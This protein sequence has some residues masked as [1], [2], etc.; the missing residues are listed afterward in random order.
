MQRR[1]GFTL[2]E[3]L[4]VIAIIAILAAILFPVFTNAKKAGQKASCA[5]GIKQLSGAFQIYADDNGNTVPPNYTTCNRPYPNG[6][7]NHQNAWLWMHYLYPYV[8]NVKVYNCPA[9]RGIFKG[10]YFWEDPKSGLYMGASYAYNRWLGRY[11]PPFDSERVSFGQISRTTV[12]PL[13][14]DCFYYLMGPKSVD[15]LGNDYPPTARHNEMAVM[16]FVDGHAQTVKRE[17]WITDNERI[18]SD[19][20]WRKWDPLL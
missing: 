8:K 2:I 17:D 16:S 19:P 9:S 3:L 5:N 11:L 12:T 20:V 14:A 18:S 7:A 4:V 1:K 15:G 6:E 13:L 10:G